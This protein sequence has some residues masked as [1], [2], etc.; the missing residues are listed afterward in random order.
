MVALALG[1]D[2]LAVVGGGEEA[3]GAAYYAP[4]NADGWRQCPAVAPGARVV[5]DADTVGMIAELEWQSKP[6][7]LQGIERHGKFGR[8]R[9]QGRQR[10]GDLAYGGRLGALGPY[11]FVGPRVGAVGLCQ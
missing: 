11:T 2:I 1:Q 10:R 8:A 3:V 5:V 4:G 6:L 7:G 9:Q